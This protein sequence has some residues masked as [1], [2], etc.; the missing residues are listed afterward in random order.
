MSQRQRYRRKPNQVV[1]AVQLTLDT[2]GFAYRKWGG[3]QRCKGGDWLVDN[4]GDVYTVAADSFARTYRRQATGQY[5]KITPIWAERASAAGEVATAEGRT[6]YQAG[7]YL[8][9]NN[10]DGTDAYAIAAAKFEAMY[11]PD[12]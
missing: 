5:L 10:E 2:D 8:V 6:R 11:E 12:A 4:D 9:S 3:E 1:A 7:D